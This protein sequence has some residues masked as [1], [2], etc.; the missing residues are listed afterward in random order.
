MPPL[1]LLWLKAAPQSNADL[2]S[3]DVLQVGGA[4]LLPETARRVWPTL[5]CTLQQVFG[6]ADGLVNYT[7]ELR[8]VQIGLINIAKSNPKNA[9]VL[10]LFNADFSK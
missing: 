1:A 7:R 3:L 8:G 10:P 4:K 5:G 6:M 9:R 2:S